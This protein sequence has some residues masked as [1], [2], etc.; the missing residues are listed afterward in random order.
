MTWAALVV[1]VVMGILLFAIVG[2]IEQWVIPW[3]VS[4]RATDATQYQH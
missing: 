1:L 2:W 3:H 4:I